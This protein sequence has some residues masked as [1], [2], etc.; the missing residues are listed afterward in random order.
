MEL[1]MFKKHFCHFLALLATPFL[2]SNGIMAE[3]TVPLIEPYTFYPRGCHII[4]DSWE[5]DCK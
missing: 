4:I 2:V 5:G 3:N 1:D